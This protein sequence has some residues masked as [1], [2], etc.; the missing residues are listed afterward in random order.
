MSWLNASE[1][2]FIETIARDRVEA[3]RSTIGWRDPH[4]AR[5]HA[6]VGDGSAESAS[7]LVMPVACIMSTVI[8]RSC[9]TRTVEENAPP[10]IM[11]VPASR[12]TASRRRVASVGARPSASSAHR[13]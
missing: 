3:L 5:E 6:C 2:F 4:P 12:A 7:S 9:A 1:Y 8:D 11:P 13:A 10:A